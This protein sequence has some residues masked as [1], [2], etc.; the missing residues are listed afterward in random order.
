MVLIWRVL[1]I[2]DQINMTDHV[3]DNSEVEQSRAR[4][5]SNHVELAPGRLDTVTLCKIDYN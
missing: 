4:G 2:H 3:T 5:S 1:Y